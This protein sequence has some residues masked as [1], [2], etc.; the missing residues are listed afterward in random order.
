MEFLGRNFSQPP[1]PI[2]YP[3]VMTA[4]TVPLSMLVAMVAGSWQLALTRYRDGVAP[5]VG[6][7]STRSW[8]RPAGG[9]DLGLNR[10]FWGY[11]ARQ[12]LPWINRTFA[13][14]AQVHFHDVIG[15]AYN[16]Y[17]K[18]GLL[19][20][21][22]FNSGMEQPAIN[23]SRYA[24]VIHEVHFNKYEYWIWDAYKTPIPLK[25]LTLDGV[26]LVTV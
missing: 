15:Y 19:R 4:F 12:L 13:R 8:L 6:D 25:V 23:R 22:I 18:E 11:P 21:D 14:G 16:Q 24:I 17:R 2:S 9:A 5:A 1:L 20:R 7:R 10:Q 26:P 3:F